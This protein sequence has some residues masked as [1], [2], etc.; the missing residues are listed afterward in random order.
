[1]VCTGSDLRRALD[2]VKVQ[3][4]DCPV[5]PRPLLAP[6]PGHPRSATPLSRSNISFELSGD[7]YSLFCAGHLFINASPRHQHQYY[8][9]VSNSRPNNLPSSAPS[10]TPPTH[11]P[12]S[13]VVP[14]S[15]KNAVASSSKTPVSSSNAAASST[16]RLERIRIR[17]RMQPLEPIPGRARTAT[18]GT[19]ASDSRANVAQFCIDG[20]GTLGRLESWRRGDEGGRARKVDARAACSPF[21]FFHRFY[22]FGTSTDI[23]SAP[24]TPPAMREPCARRTSSGC[25][26]EGARGHQ[27]HADAGNVSPGI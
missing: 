16:G 19:T 6:A 13:T 5:V 20:R 17:G 2:L 24:F 27:L 25:T 10:P 12:L 18:P 1:M 11:A 3:P 22:F 9:R 21:D 15:S 7:I 26:R 23:P 4:A 8:A 14:S